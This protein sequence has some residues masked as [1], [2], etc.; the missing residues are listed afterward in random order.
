M[1]YILYNTPL[2][3]QDGADLGYEVFLI[4]D[5]TAPIAL[6]VDDTTTTVDTAMADMMS[7]GVSIIS[8]ADMGHFECPARRSMEEKPK[9]F[10]MKLG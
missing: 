3:A 8:M 9:G 10:T 5:A 6:P 1:I 7:K 2:L 4:E